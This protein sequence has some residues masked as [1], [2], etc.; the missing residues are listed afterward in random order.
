MPIHNV[1]SQNSIFANG[2][3]GIDLGNDGVTPNS[4]TSFDNYPVILAA[5]AYPNYTLVRY[6]L[7]PPVGAATLEFFANDVA[8]P[9]GYGQGQHFVASTL[10]IGNA[11]V[12][13][14]RLPA[15]PVGTVLTATSTLAG[16]PIGDA[17]NTSE[18]A[19]DVTVIAPPPKVVSAAFNP[20]NNTLAF[21]FSRD[22]SAS[23]SPSS[24]RVHNLTT[25]SD[26]AVT[27][28]TYDGSTNVATFQLPGN[29]PG[30][31]YVVTLLARAVM[32]ASGEQ[33]DGNGDGTPGDDYAFNFSST[34]GDVNLDGAVSF[35][36]L[37]ILA[38]NFGQAGTFAQGDL[39][40]DGTIDFADLLILAQ[41]FGHGSAAA[42]LLPL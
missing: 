14:I 36:D 16:N 1:V 39:N 11:L 18:F 13:A 30:G 28:V 26:V 37:L 35:P 21:T 40:H 38:R 7:V 32:D 15:L 9:S 25:G 2:K 5:T 12:Y 33:L 31:S 3:L 23:L 6:Q 22:V 34:A 19:K 17:F 27:G 24:V 8:D 29:L 20:Q 10:T 4:S 42:T 41:N